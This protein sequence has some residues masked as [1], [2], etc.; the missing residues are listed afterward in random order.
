MK[1]PHIDF[2][3]N[4]KWYFLLSTAL[5]V[6]GIIAIFVNGVKLDIQ[7]TGGTKISYNY[8]VDTTKNIA[9]IDADKAANI[10]AGATD[11]NVSVQKAVSSTDGRSSLV[12]SLSGKESLSTEEQ[13]KIDTA[14]MDAYKDNDVTLDTI[15][16]IEPYIG[17]RFLKNG[18]IAVVAAAVLIFIFVMIRFSLV[19]GATAAMT[20]LISLCHDLLMVFF[21]FVIFNIPLN[22]AFI[23]VF[24]TVLGYSVNDTLV[25]YDR[26][27]ENK[28]L[29][30]NKL[31]IPELVNLSI[32]QTISR[33][34]NT[35]ILTFTAMLIV[36]IFAQLNGITSIVNFALPLMVGIVSGCYSSVCLSSVIWGTIK[37][38]GKKA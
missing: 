9:D 10:V 8:T 3:K 17:A 37:L 4:R 33:C 29:H 20:A 24:L 19:S 1:I 32:N 25:I 22:D 35:S 13:K 11:R 2:F 15:N 23:A 36:F 26:I 21:V 18:I 5:I 7:F 30:G 31:S 6:V 28:N 12:I 38:K 16:N 14:L 34:I 27:R